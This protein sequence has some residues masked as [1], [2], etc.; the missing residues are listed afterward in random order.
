MIGFGFTFYKFL[1]YLQ[2]E[3]AAPLMRL[4]GPRNL[5]LT[6]IGLGVVSLALAT[7]HYWLFMKRVGASDGKSPVTVTLAVA[8]VVALVGLFAV[9]NVLFAIGPF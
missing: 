8:S 7:V 2:Q 4:Q 6:L 3:G 1:Q 5:G 9:M